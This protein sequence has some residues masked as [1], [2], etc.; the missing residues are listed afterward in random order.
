MWARC[1]H[2]NRFEIPAFAWF[3]SRH[4]PDAASFLVDGHQF[5]G[6]LRSGS[7]LEAGEETLRAVVEDSELEQEVRDM[8]MRKFSDDVSM[9][10]DLRQ[11]VWERRAVC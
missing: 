9:Q 6:K 4:R 7:V 8:D 1:G 10:E 5:Q 3:R 11:V 2:A